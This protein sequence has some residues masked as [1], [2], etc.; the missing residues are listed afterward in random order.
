MTTELVRD[1]VGHISISGVHGRDELNERLA[2][3]PAY[4][5]GRRSPLLAL[6]LGAALGAGLMYLFKRE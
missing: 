5:E 6:L 1:P 4:E 3:A 2:N